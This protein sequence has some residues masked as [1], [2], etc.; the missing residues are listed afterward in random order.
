MTEDEKLELLD[1][2]STEITFAK[3]QSVAVA[4]QRINYYELKK[5]SE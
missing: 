3:S 4:G 5:N 2:I 1:M